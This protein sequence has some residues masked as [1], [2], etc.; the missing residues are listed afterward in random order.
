MTVN[1]M[2]FSRQLT[3][4][5]HVFKTYDL[6][7]KTNQKLRKRVDALEHKIR[8]LGQKLGQ[9][10]QGIG[11]IEQKTNQ[12]LMETFSQRGCA[13][14]VGN[15]RI[16][17]KVVIG[18]TE[19]AFYVEADDR[20]LTPWFI[21]SGVY[22]PGVT[23]YFLRELRADSNCIDVGS[24]FGYFTCLMARF[25]PRGRV[26]GIEAD[27]RIAA[28]AQ[29]NIFI[30][31]LHS[32]A[33]VRHAAAGRSAEPLTLYR[34]NA[35]SGNTSIAKLPDAFIKEMGEV[36]SE[37]FTVDSIPLDD[38]LPEM[39]GHVDFV[40]VDAEGAEPLVFEGARR[41]IEGNPRLSIIMEWSPGQIV[42]AGFAVEPFLA[43]LEALGLQPHGLVSG[44]IESITFGELAG[45]PYRSAIVLRRP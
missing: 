18:G 7:E 43:E 34:R 13:T 2:S 36:P 5:E 17:T 32:H 22:E 24:N 30:N 28:L 3:K 11:Q 26:I 35:R 33:H 27:E 8:K 20:L 12:L 29:D 41:I 45:L 31:G 37:P 19:I 15:N 23:E 25:C 6:V 21:L 42:A 38:L 16:L 44:G 39:D 9:V 4:L 14:Y 40:K 1:A 10:K